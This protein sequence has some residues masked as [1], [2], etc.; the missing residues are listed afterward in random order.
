[1]RLLAK[2][3]LPLAWPV[4]EWW[5]GGW[6]LRIAWAYFGGLLVGGLAWLVVLL[7]ARQKAGV[8]S[9]AFWISYTFAVA[10]TWLLQ[11][12]IIAQHIRA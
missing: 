7:R 12:S 1:V 3:R 11:E 10:Q 6:K 4:A 9:D 8:N 2:R 5:G